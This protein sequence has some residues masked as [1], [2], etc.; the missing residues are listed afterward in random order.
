MDKQSRI[1][2]AGHRGMVGSAIWNLLESKGFN[3]LIGKTRG[4][5]DLKKIKI[6]NIIEENISKNPSVMGWLV[7][8]KIIEITMVN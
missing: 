4:E 5:L 1:Y 7:A 3:N 8:K 6:E 2:I